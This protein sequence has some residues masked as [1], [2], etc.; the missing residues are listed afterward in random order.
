MSPADSPF[1]KF[2]WKHN[3]TSDNSAAICMFM[4]GA[5]W[6]KNVFTNPLQKQIMFPHAWSKSLFECS[7]N[8]LLSRWEVNYSSVPRKI[9]KWLLI[10][11]SLARVVGKVTLDSLDSLN[12]IWHFDNLN[13][14]ARQPCANWVL[15]L[16][17][18][19]FHVC[20]MGN[21]EWLWSWL[22]KFWRS[23]SWFKSIHR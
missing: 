10:P 18:F 13:F 20:G 9:I 5:A 11:N 23:L 3:S 17:E 12:K 4:L 1:I 2:W 21:L 14:S 6:E 8:N 16:S 15:S 22:G 19:P 7:V